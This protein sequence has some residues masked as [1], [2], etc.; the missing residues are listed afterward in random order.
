MG[1]IISGVI[2]DRFAKDKENPYS[3]IVI[4]SCALSIPFYGLA[5]LNQ[6][7]FWLSMT[8]YGITYLIVETWHAPYVTMLQ[9]SSKPE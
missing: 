6:D 5:F 4:A 9:N 1:A 2:A 3:K 7:N 8:L